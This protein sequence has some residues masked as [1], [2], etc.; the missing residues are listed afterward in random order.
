M[1]DAVTVF[2][3]ISIVAMVL[4]AT[5]TRS[6]A[7]AF[8]GLALVFIAAT[9]LVFSQE[10]LQ[11]LL[12]IPLLIGGLLALVLAAALGSNF[13]SSSISRTTTDGEHWEA[14]QTLFGDGARNS[15]SR[16]DWHALGS[17][18]SKDFP[19]IGDGK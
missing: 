4:M 2:L 17:G 11:K 3:L 7:G 6:I 10:G 12:G 19:K 18:S 9:M 13:S 14:H 8:V 16:A 5:L 1:Q 15:S